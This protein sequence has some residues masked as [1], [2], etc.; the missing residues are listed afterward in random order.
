MEFGLRPPPFLPPVDPTIDAAGVRRY[1]GNTYAQTTGYRPVLLD[2]HVPPSAE[3]VGAVVWIHGGAWLD[4]DRRYPPPTVDPDAL[5]GGIVRAGLAL[6]RVD[7]RHSLESPFPAQL[8]DVEAAIRYVREFA[9]EFGIDPARIGVWGESAG[10]HL[11][12]LLA[13]ADGLEGTVGVTGPSSD[14]S[15]VV[16]WYGVADV[17]A[18]LSRLHS[19]EQPDPCEAL[20]GPRRDQW[21]ML[22]AAASP[23]NYLDRGRGPVI[24]MLIQHGTA[25]SVVPF[26]HSERLAKALA[27]AGVPVT[28]VP[29][30]EADHCFAGH[31]DVPEIVQRGIAFLREHLS[32]CAHD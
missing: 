32:P 5:F 12:S 18:L 1:D 8:H 3:P 30:P 20:L 2:V 21:P 27:A 10:G 6:V 31:P 13:L 4:G 11:A 16:N 23:I 7:Y 26:D 17:A 28:F 14:V 9:G 22:A 25:D 29:V 15:A 19:P 24:P